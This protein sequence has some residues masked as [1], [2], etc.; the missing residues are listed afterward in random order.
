MHYPELYELVGMVSI[1]PV[2]LA[3]NFHLMK[4]VRILLSE[5]DNPD[6]S[7][8]VWLEEFSHDASRSL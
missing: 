3:E 8:R 6:D 5:I 7:V 1:Q 2:T 4:N